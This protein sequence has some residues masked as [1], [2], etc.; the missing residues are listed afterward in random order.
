MLKSAKTRLRRS[1]RT[2]KRMSWTNASSA[3]PP[4]ALRVSSVDSQDVPE[5]A[6]RGLRA[7]REPRHAGFGAQ[8]FLFRE[9]KL[10]FVGQVPVVFGPAPDAQLQ[11]LP[12]SI[13]ATGHDAVL[14][15]NG[16]P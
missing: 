13:V 3:V 11:P 2:E 14:S 5:V 4:R 7:P 10:D 16:E 1:R 15:G 6:T 12:P 8:P 9:V